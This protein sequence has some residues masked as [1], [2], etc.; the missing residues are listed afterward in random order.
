MLLLPLLLLMMMMMMM[1]ELLSLEKREREERE[2]RKKNE[3][4][5][6]KNLLSEK[7]LFTCFLASS[8]SALV[9]PRERG[10]TSLAKK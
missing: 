10:S 6:K 9:G 7:E 4:T 8:F 1:R 5:G 3:K 2:E